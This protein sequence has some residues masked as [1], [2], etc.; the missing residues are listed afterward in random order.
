MSTNYPS[1]LPS[2]LASSLP[3]KLLSSAFFAVVKTRNFWFNHIRSSPTGTGHRTI[4]IGGIRAGGTGKT[5]VTLLVARYFLE[6]DINVA[7]LSR[8]YGRKA[9]AHKILLSGEKAQWQEIG[10]EPMMLLKELPRIHLGI[11]ADRVK[12]ARLLNEKVLPETIFILDDAFQHRRIKR[13]LD[14]VC[15]QENCLDERPM[16]QGYLREPI[17]S[18]RR[19]H[20]A[21]LI[22]KSENVHTLKETQRKIIE[23]FPG[24]KV[25]LLLQKQSHWV[26]GK[27]G[28]QAA[29]PAVR[30]P[31]LV[32]GIA[33]PERF[34]DMVHHAGITPAKKLL[35]PDHHRFTEDDFAGDKDLFSG[36]IITTEKDFMRINSLKVVLTMNI[37][38]LKIVTIF[39][40]PNEEKAFYS[41][42]TQ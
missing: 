9:K 12:N 20:A 19:A 6:R 2:W 18:L 27:S 1:P 39:N 38:Y 31:V 32:C 10:D 13:D 7:I 41:L 11:G 14:I 24:L 40:D 15:L 37:W 25:Y 5:P 33:R 35:F 4:S 29:E 17:D 36:G 21:L 26:Q 28:E 3:V 22:G 30:N 23:R 34:I 8:G 42:L 16:P